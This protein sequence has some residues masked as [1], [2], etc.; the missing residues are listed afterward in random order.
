[1]FVNH[2]VNV[3]SF[4]DDPGSL[5]RKR[6]K[7]NNSPNALVLRHVQTEAEKREYFYQIVFNSTALMGMGLNNVIGVVESSKLFRIHCTT[8]TRFTSLELIFIFTF[9]SYCMQETKASYLSDASNQ[10][11][12]HFLNG[13]ISP[14][15]CNDCCNEYRKFVESSKNL[16]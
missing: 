4:I 12:V 11:V 2:V 8:F 3:Q 13:V 14:I 16:I 1:M 9:I 5:R 7:F 10:Y 6:Q 15:C